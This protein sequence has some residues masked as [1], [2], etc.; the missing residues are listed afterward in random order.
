MEFFVWCRDR[1][2]T[3]AIRRQLTGDHW[4]YMD[5]FATRMIARGPALGADGAPIGSLH[6]LDLPDPDAARAFAFE[7]PFARAGV[8]GE[9]RIRRWAN[10]LGRTMWDWPADPGSDQRFLVIGTGREAMT[11]QRTALLPAHQAFLND[12]ARAGGIILRGP[13]LSDDGTDWLGSAMLLQQ[14]DP[15]AARALFTHEPYHAGG[16][17]AGLEILPWRFGGRH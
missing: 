12:P 11:A 15:A 17:Y 14:P 9:V 3:A 13:L 6:I 5:R 7:E 4:T 1:P 10:A 2:D 8:F 16:L